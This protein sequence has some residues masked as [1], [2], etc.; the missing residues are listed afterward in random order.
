MSQI[1]PILLQKLGQLRRRERFLRFAWGA[2]RLLAVL[3][4]ALLL[5]CL[6]DWT[7]DLWE[8]TPFALRV[9]MIAVQGTL[10]AIGALL[11]IILPICRRIRNERMALYVEYHQPQLQHRLI[12]ALQLNREDAPTEGMSPEMLDAMTREAEDQCRR[13]SF[14]GFADHRRLRRGAI[15]LAPLILVMAILAIA[16]PATA[17]ALLQRQALLDVEI[18][19]DI[20]VWS[21]TPAVWPSGEEVL[22]SFRASGPE[23]AERTGSVRITTRD[24]SNFTLPLKHES[25]GNAETWFVARVPP[26]SADFAFRA[27]LGDG[28]MRRAAHVHYVPRPNVIQQDGYLILPDYVG[29]KPYG[30]PYEQ[31]QPGG[32]IT[33]MPELSARIV[34]KTQ[35]KVFRAVLET[36]GTPYPNL[37]GTGG[38]TKTQQGYN[39]LLTQLATASASAGVLGPQPPPG[40][41]LAAAAHEPVPLR[42]FTQRFVTGYDE[43]KWTIDLRP[44]ETSYR[45][46]VFDE[47][48]FASKTATVR[49]IKIEPE[50]PPVVVLHPERFDADP[51][52]NKVSSKSAQ[53]LDFEG[54]PLPVD[55]EGR[56][57]AIHLSYEAFGP[58][59]IGKAQ[60]KIGVIRGANDS[61]EGG[62]K[63]IEY[64]VTLPLAEV[65]ASDR[66][67][68]KARG[69]FVNSD[70]KEQVPFYAVPSPAGPARLPRVIAGGR[71]DYQ[72]AKLL[73]EDGQPF[74]FKIDDQIVVYLEV[75]NQNPDPQKALVARSKLR[76]KDLVS[77]EKFL[78]WCFDTLQ[79]A[80]RIEALLQLQ[81]QV[82]DRPWQ[83]IGGGK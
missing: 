76:E 35:K 74:A 41:G 62:K 36:F 37:A 72:P 20:T 25:G 13:L 69:A 47:Y 79:E 82:Y 6:I 63:K 16:C 15:L 80:S 54:M 50:P 42:T 52:F 67:F 33:G 81:Q 60:L 5:A 30:R 58:Y 66:E 68:D 34:V 23:A 28:R 10:A 32:D 39:Q 38:L 22:L 46:L 75:F 49:A 1:P 29:L 43:V 21:E 14:A 18:P 31:L 27:K 64:W 57:K 78:N 44:T 59:G 8:D 61:E 2:A 9:I 73:G 19:R 53:L 83:S 77:Q 7:V 71:F 40:L 26:G 4:F 45:V 55:D 12:S 24:G 51:Q 56:P 3:L 65:K 70:K 17:W 48:G 11:L